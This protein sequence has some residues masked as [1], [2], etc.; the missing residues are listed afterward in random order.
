MLFSPFR[1]LLPSYPCLCECKQDSEGAERMN[2]VVGDGRRKAHHSHTLKPIQ[3]CTWLVSCQSLPYVFVLWIVH[4]GE[5]ERVC[6]LASCEMKW[7]TA[8]EREG[9]AGSGEAAG[10]GFRGAVRCGP[11]ST[12]PPERWPPAPVCPGSDRR[13]AA[14]QSWRI[15]AVRRSLVHTA[16]A[17]IPAEETRKKGFIN[18][19]FYI[20]IYHP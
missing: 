4:V 6:V 16:P 10:L 12:T 14:G 1:F 20:Y 9:E 7:K 17:Q 11:V 8:E 3:A 13:S 2:V 19:T 5:G 18:I 15:P